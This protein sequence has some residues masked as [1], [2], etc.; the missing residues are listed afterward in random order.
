MEEL[1]E[2]V[3]NFVED[4]VEIGAVD[5]DSDFGVAVEELA[6]IVVES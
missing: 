5:A 6:L 1:N 3:L 4:S 2:P